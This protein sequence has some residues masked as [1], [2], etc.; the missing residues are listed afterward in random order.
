M[1]VQKLQNTKAIDK[2]KAIVPY[3]YHSNLLSLG[4]LALKK[5][6]TQ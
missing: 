4:T 3:K 1:Q 6:T 2:L 5:T